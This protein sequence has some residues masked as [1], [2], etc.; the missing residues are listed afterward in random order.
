MIATGNS[1]SISAGPTVSVANIATGT[2]TFRFLNAN[3]SAV[4]YVGVF[5][6]YAAASA[7]HHPSTGSTV[8]GELIALAPY[9]AETIAGNFGINPN[10]G[11]VYVAAITGTSSGQVVV[12]T[13]IFPGS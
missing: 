2:N 7:T 10:P 3:A 6:T 4:S 8:G 11:T 5:S 9:Q 13:P 12:A 1:I